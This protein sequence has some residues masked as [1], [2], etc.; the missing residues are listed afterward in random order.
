M[1]IRSLITRNLRVVF[2]IILV[3][4]FSSK[5]LPHE[6]TEHDHDT[7]GHA[8]ETPVA[9]PAHGEDESKVDITEVAFEHSLDAH[10]WHLWGDREHPVSFPL[11]LIL[12]TNAGIVTFMSSA[13]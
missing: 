13:F 4:V 6:P 10:S 2:S 12:K 7:T 11:P 3:L 9:T 5:F 8:T 1:S